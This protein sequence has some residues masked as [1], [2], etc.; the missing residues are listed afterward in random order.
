M[1]P[2]LPARVAH[3]DPRSLVGPGL[4]RAH[5]QARIKAEPTGFAALDRVL[6]GGGWP[7]GAISEVLHPGPGVGEV[8]LAL[9][10]LARTTSAGR[11]AAWVAPPTLPHA[12]RLA[13]AGI[14]LEHL[15]VVETGSAT[16]ALLS[17]ELLLRAGGVVLLWIAACETQALRRLQ[18]AAEAGDTGLIALRPDRYAAQATPSALRLRI[19]REPGASGIE[20]LKC[21]GARPAP[22]RLHAAA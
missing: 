16:E 6:P 8:S 1:E 7:L 21:R 3:R 19:W 14:R 2:A 5:E 13:A 15:H 9:P 12:P 10:L 20:V 11:P 17:A 4:W 22:L 18:L